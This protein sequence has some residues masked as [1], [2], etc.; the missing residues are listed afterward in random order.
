MIDKRY[1]VIEVNSKRIDVN[2]YKNKAIVIDL[3]TY[4]RFKLEYVTENSRFDIIKDVQRY[5]CSD[6]ASLNIDSIHSMRLIQDQRFIPMGYDNGLCKI[7][8]ID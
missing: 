7:T 3:H 8:K 2:K 4:E 1:D 6:I 5:E